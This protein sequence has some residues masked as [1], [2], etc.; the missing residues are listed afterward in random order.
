MRQSFIRWMS[1][2]VGAV[3]LQGCTTLFNPWIVS[4]YALD[5]YI[6][7]E[8]WTG[9]TWSGEDRIVMA[10]VKATFGSRG[11]RSINGPFAWT[12]PVTGEQMQVYERIN[13]T[14]AG[15]KRQL[16]T[17]NPEQTGLAKVYDERPGMKTRYFSTNAVLFPLGNWRRSEK[18]DFI[19]DEYVDGKP[20]RRTATLHIRRLSFNYKGVPYAIKFDYLMHDD[21]G[22]LVFHERFIYGPGKRLM[23]FKDR[24]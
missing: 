9:E 19:F 13:R 8:M 5:R 6:P 12:H 17:V 7:V 2:V 11:Q 4:K 18:K 1:V 20:V 3:V 24:M 21:S 23:Y 10:P 22:A 16:F 15:T 14:A